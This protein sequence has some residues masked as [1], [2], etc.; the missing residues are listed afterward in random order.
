MNAQIRTINDYYKG[1]SNIYFFNQGQIAQ[2]GLVGLTDA[3]NNI[4]QQLIGRKNLQ[5]NQIKQLENCSKKAKIAHKKIAHKLVSLYE[6]LF[7]FNSC[8]LSYLHLHFNHLSTNIIQS[9]RF[10]YYCHLVI[11]VQLLNSFQSIHFNKRS[12]SLSYASSI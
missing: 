3:P 5:L 7:T 9:L 4:N 11:C 10:R 12:L 2:K 8:I 1:S 6:S